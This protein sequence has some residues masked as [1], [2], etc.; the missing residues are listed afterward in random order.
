MTNRNRQNNRN[1]PERDDEG[2]FVSDDD[3][4]GRRNGSR[5]ESHA[6]RGDYLYDEDEDDYDGNRTYSRGN[7]DDQY[8]RSY[9]SHNMPQRDDEGRFASNDRYQGS[10]GGGRYE[11]DEDYSDNRSQGRSYG[12]SSGYEDEDEEYYSS[13][14]RGY[15]TQGRNGNGRNGQQNRGGRGG[16]NDDYASSS[17]GGALYSTAVIGPTSP[18]MRM[19]WARTSSQ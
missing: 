19:S 1:T 15:S 7:H 14:E 13:N 5:M 6:S 2:R 10:R 8:E 4:Q 12:R 16:Y 11:D 17:R 9:R 18:A 3:R